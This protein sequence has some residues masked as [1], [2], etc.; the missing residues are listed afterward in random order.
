MEDY[1][2]KQA[3]LE[4]EYV[5]KF[6]GNDK[7][8]EPFTVTL[9]QLS[10]RQVNGAIEITVEGP[11]VNYEKIFINGLVKVNRFKVDG[12]QIVTADDILDTPG[13]YPLFTELTVEIQNGNLILDTDLKN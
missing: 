2:I 1:E 11:K 10:T 13:L 8:T 6:R 5:P 12:K 9:K 7:R 3:P 4:W